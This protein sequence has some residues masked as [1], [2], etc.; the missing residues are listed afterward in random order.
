[1]SK[2]NKAGVIESGMFTEA[3][4][5]IYDPAWNV[6]Q[7]GIPGWISVI[8]TGYEDVYLR[9][10]NQKASLCSIFDTHIQA[11]EFIEI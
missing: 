3:F 4:G 10:D 5:S 1:M 8:T 7:G 11:V 9:V 2:I 6:H